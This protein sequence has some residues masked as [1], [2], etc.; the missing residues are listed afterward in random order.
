MPKMPSL[1]KG[2]KCIKLLLSKASK[3]IYDPLFPMFFPS[4]GARISEAEFQY[5]VLTIP[6]YPPLF[7]KQVA[8]SAK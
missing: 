5:P 6:K 4:L 1:G 3:D 2:T 8:L 7:S